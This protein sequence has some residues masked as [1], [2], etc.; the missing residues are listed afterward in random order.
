MRVWH[1]SAMCWTTPHGYFLDGFS[2]PLQAI[3]ECSSPSRWCEWGCAG[4]RTQT[5][6]TLSLYTPTP[7]FR[8][9]LTLRCL[10]AAYDLV[11]SQG[12]TAADPWFFPRGLL[13]YWKTSVLCSGALLV[14]SSGSW[15]THQPS[16]PRDWTRIPSWTFLNTLRESWGSKSFVADNL[17]RERRAPGWN[18][19]I[20][21]PTPERSR[22]RSRLSRARAL[23]P[24]RSNCAHG[25]RLCFFFR[26]T[27]PRWLG[28]TVLRWL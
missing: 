14:T 9:A 27:T 11:G 4:N 6:R 13:K 15:Q 23:R 16:F 24:C 21:P 2:S 5:R 26:R 17:L 20:L 19:S 22:S 3:L 1:E 12:T 8:M 10:W 25:K 7:S 28:G 18:G